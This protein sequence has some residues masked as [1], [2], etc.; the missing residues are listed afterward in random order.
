MRRKIWIGLGIAACFIAAIAVC[1]GLRIG[2]LLPTWISWN[3]AR[4]EIDG[5]TQLL[6]SK[7]RVSVTA[8]GETVWRSGRELRVQDVLWCD[9]D[10]DEESELL[11][12]CWKRGRYGSSRPFW[13]EE[14][15]KTWS[16][17]IYIYDWN[18]GEPKPVWMASDIGL[19]AASWTFDEVRRLVIT[20]RTG[21]QTAWDWVTWGLSRIELRQTLTFAALG[22]NLIHY[23]IY[24]YAF[25]HFDGCFDDL[26]AQIAPELEQYDVTSINQ[27][28]ILVDDPGR[29]SS[30]PLF[31]TPLQVGD[32]VVKAGF[33]IVTCATNHALDMGPDAIERTAALF[34][35]AG[36][37]CAGIQSAEDGAFRP[38]EILERNGIR[39]AVFNYT[40][41]T[42]G[43]PLPED[44]PYVVHTLDDEQQVREGLLAGRA[45]ADLC[46][47]YV[48]WGTEYAEQPDDQQR[49]WAQVFADCGA[50]VVIGTHPHVLQPYEW[51]TG[52]DGHETLVYYS[53][54]NF[55]SAQTEEA[56]RRGGLAHFTVVKENGICSVFDW[57]MK[58][59]V[60]EEENGHYTTRLQEGVYGA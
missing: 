30:Y 31:G 25:R 51:V 43:Q 15:E 41:T 13:V 59:L 12:L 54:G 28:T 24:D 19:E 44:A 14:D 55:I 60:T 22:D 46:L 26:F 49:Y 42:N 34:R 58:T 6:L 29:Y 27:E 17:H 36:I 38:Y 39:C 37:V 8:E 11:L 33:D 48:H 32:A 47:V 53:L 1:W 20:D 10:R 9:V 2:Y 56:C 18:A 50:D 52:R 45:E 57:G 40:L 35:D 4:I 3:T 23:Q 21:E 5:Q 16:Q 7:K